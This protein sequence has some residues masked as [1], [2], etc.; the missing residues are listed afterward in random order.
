MSRITRK[1]LEL[2]QKVEKNFPNP[3]LQSLEQKLQSNNVQLYGKILIKDALYLFLY[4][5]LYGLSYKNLEVTFKY[6]HSDM[7]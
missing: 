4:W 1:S 2:Q 6:S 3:I 5:M 7:H